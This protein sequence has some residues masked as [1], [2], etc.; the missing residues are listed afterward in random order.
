[1]Y[2]YISIIYKN[3]NFIFQIFL[4]LKEYKPKKLE[5]ER[6]HFIY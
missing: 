1:M 4:V 6:K 5:F 3:K 2:A